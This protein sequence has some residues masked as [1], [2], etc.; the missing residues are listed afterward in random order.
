M[1]IMEEIKE[2]SARFFI[3][4]NNQC[5]AELIC[6]LPDKTTLL[7]T[8]TEV[9]DSLGGKGIGKQLVSAAVNYA[10]QNAYVVKATCSYANA[11]LDKTLKYADVNVA[12]KNHR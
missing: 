8:H 2:N 5:V 6:K 10:K 1:E 9:N 3:G 11:V 7:I 12:E 4:E